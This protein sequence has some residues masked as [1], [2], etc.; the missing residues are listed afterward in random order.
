MTFTGASI[1]LSTTTDMSGAY[2]FG[3]LYAGTYMITSHPRLWYNQ[4]SPTTYTETLTAE[5]VTQSRDFP[6]TPKNE[7]SISGSV[8]HDVEKNNIRESSNPLLSGVKISLSGTTYTGASLTRETTTDVN[9]YYEFV[10]LFSG[11][12]IVSVVP[13]DGYMLSTMLSASGVILSVNPVEKV[14][15]DFPLVTPTNTVSGIAFIDIDGNGIYTT[16]SGGTE[17]TDPPM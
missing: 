13:L 9:G 1:A 15:R 3:G 10:S 16:G 17:T 14:T 7:A 5:S 4:G 6:Y 2:Y 8:Y 12:Y 11:T